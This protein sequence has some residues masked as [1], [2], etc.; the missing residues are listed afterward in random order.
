MCMCF[1]EDGTIWRPHPHPQGLSQNLVTPLLREMRER[2]TVHMHKLKDKQSFIT[3]S[4]SGSL[5]LITTG[6]SEQVDTW[7]LDVMATTV[8]VLRQRFKGRHAT[9]CSHQTLRDDPKNVLVRG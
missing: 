9:F 5:K 2:M 7:I 3:H 1:E 4:L 6:T 8:Q